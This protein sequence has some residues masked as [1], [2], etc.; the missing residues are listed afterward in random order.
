M[1]M[2]AA[3]S[4][5]YYTGKGATTVSQVPITSAGSSGLLFTHPS[6]FTV[7]PAALRAPTSWRKNVD[8]N[9]ILELAMGVTEAQVTREE[10][11]PE[12]IQERKEAWRGTEKEKDFIMEKKRQSGLTNK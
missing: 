1:G 9:C 5:L 7:R 3:S 2:R 8:S 12:E 6:M 4:Q 10:S 11:K